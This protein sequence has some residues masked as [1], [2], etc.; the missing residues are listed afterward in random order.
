M[1]TLS[2]ARTIR[3]VMIFALIAF[4]MFVIWQNSAATSVSFL[5]FSAELPLMVWLGLFLVVGMLLGIA[6]MWSYRRRA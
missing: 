3:L 5:F 4:L 1:Q 2:K 6:F